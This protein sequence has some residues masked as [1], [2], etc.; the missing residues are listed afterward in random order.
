M[1]ELDFLW[2]VKSGTVDI[3]KPRWTDSR[4]VNE[5]LK[6]DPERW[7]QFKLGKCTYRDMSRDT[8]RRAITDTRNRL[9]AAGAP[10]RV[11]GA[12]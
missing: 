3:G 4:I 1:I 8:L 11:R 12:L 9:C 10:L 6:P 7:K 2:L 5:L